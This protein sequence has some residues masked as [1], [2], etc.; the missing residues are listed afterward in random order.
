[1]NILFFKKGL[2]GLAFLC[3]IVVVSAQ[4]LLPVKSGNLWGYVN[5]KGEVVI[6][7]KYDFASEAINGFCRARKAKGLDIIFSPD[8]IIHFDDATA[9]QVLNK[10]NYKVLINNKWYLTDLNGNILNNAGFE[11]LSS[12]SENDSISVFQQLNKRGVIN[13]NG[14]IFLSFNCLTLKSVKYGLYIAR[15]NANKEVLINRYGKILA[16]DTF[17]NIYTIDKTLGL[18]L[19]YKHP[20]NYR[21]IDTTGKIYLMKPSLSA[22]SETHSPIIRLYAIKEARYYFLDFA[23]QGKMLSSFDNEVVNTFSPDVFIFKNKNA[24]M[25]LYHLKRG[26]IYSAKNITI[27]NLN[28]FIKISGDTLK[29]TGKVKNLILDKNFTPCSDTLLSNIEWAGNNRILYFRDSSGGALYNTLTQNFES[30]FIY[31]F[32]NA[33]TSFIKAYKDN[34]EMHLFDIDEKGLLSSPMVFKNTV[35]VAINNKDIEFAPLVN[36]SATLSTNSFQAPSGLRKVNWFSIQRNLNVSGGII[37]K[38]YFGLYKTNTNNKNDT[39]IKPT[40]ASVRVLDTAPLSIAFYMDDNANY[41][42][43]YKQSDT[44]LPASRVVVNDATGKIISPRAAWIDEKELVNPVL[45][46]YRIFKDNQFLLISKSN[47]KIIT[48]GTFISTATTNGFRRKQANGRWI[49]ATALSIPEPEASISFQDEFVKFLIQNGLYNNLSRAVQ[50]FI[51]GPRWTLIDPDGL[52][53]ATEHELGYISEFNE[54]MAIFKSSKTGLYGVIDSLGKTVVNPQYN[55]IERSK[56]SSHLFSCAN[57][58]VRT[59]IIDIYGNPVTNPLF[60]NVV[61]RGDISVASIGD[62]MF[63]ISS[64][65]GA[66][67]VGKNRRMVNFY[68]GYGFLRDKKGYRI[69][70][71]RG[72]YTSEQ[73]F[74]N[75]MPFHNGYAMVKENA[76]WQIINSEGQAMF[77]SNYKVALGFQKTTAI[78]KIRKSYCFVGLDGEKIKKSK[79]VNAETEI[80]EGVF[81]YRYKDGKYKMCNAQGKKLFKKRFHEIPILYRNQIIAK[82]RNT[83]H[84]FDTDGQWILS[85]E[86][87]KK[88]HLRQEFLLENFGATKESWRGGS[89][90]HVSPAQLYAFTGDT[91]NSF[92]SVNA[93]LNFVNT[94]NYD[95]TA[96]L[97]DAYLC[98]DFFNS[99]NFKNSNSQILYPYNFTKAS[100]FQNNLSLCSVNRKA[101]LLDIS[102]YWSIYPK[103]DDLKYI[104]DSLCT[105]TLANKWTLI[106]GKGKIINP[107]PAD[108]ITFKD[109]IAVICF[110]SGIHY[111]DINSSSYIWNKE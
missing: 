68:D 75:V 104:N 12:S 84:F 80:A 72:N 40:F 78:F 71:E 90:L 111:Y 30:D 23:N 95:F 49:A 106:D 93:P 14:D 21:V 87:N 28:G 83:A 52:P 88:N 45:S 55:N 19:G 60:K 27:S 2:S 108:F 24:A 57:S 54:G 26:I 43:L 35:Y 15:I 96:F 74:K 82:T 105:Y 102:G 67:Y 10:L 5:T 76:Y 33:D 69:T 47:G 99:Y 92:V 63:L 103:Y 100:P 11:R 101:G 41:F 94:A 38:S 6:T 61:K 66:V 97:N 18:F 32:V 8:K 31:T 109:R 107:E 37:S 59:G 36:W 34:G 64:Q 39:L 79:M 3:A 56:F 29:N 62:S 4:E 85:R 22:T 46:S 16:G 86:M 81:I 9:F 98:S 42:N 48:K 91:T 58:K 17:T 110:S 20:N 65:N 53:V 7:P 1:M 13:Y 73:T 51:E 25:Y 89:T 50:L 70:D 77:K 44:K